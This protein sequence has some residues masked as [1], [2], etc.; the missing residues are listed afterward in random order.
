MNHP[1][2]ER[3]TDCTVVPQILTLLSKRT[4]IS[5]GPLEALREGQRLLESALLTQKYLPLPRTKQHLYWP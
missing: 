2:S 5:N 1:Q 3:L 4:R